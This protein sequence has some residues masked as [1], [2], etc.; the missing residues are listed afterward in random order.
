MRCDIDTL[1]APFA[2]VV[3]GDGTLPEMLLNCMQFRLVAD[4]ASKDRAA[5]NHLIQLQRHIDHTRC[6]E[7]RGYVLGRIVELRARSAWQ[8][9]DLGED[10]PQA[11]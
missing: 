1:G 6:S 5:A 8:D 9:R 7:C 4:L 10:L 3:F 11:Q 2:V